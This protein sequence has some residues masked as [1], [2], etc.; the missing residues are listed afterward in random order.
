MW[1]VRPEL[2]NL[3]PLIRRSRT[4]ATGAKIHVS[5]DYYKHS[6]NEKVDCALHCPPREE[7]SNCYAVYLARQS[8]GGMIALAVWWVLSLVRR[9]SRDIIG[10]WRMWAM[11]RNGVGIF[12]KR[13]CRYCERQGRYSF[14]DN[15]RVRSRRPLLNRLSDGTLGDD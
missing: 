12:A 13:I 7:L 15:N 11:P 6:R 10:K 2:S 4:T 9:S 3:R 14:G 8:L 5:D 1:L